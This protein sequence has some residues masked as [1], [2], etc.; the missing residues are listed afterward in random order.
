MQLRGGIQRA[1]KQCRMK[2]QNLRATTGGAFGKNRESFAR[3][4][5]RGNP[6]LRLMRRSF[7]TALNEFGAGA[8]HQ[9]ANKWPY[10][11]I[12]FGDERRG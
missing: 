8:R 11:D 4:Q 10:S 7:A 6:L 9:P 1:L 12:A 2:R 3:R 5:P